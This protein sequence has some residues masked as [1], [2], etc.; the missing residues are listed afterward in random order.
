VAG[1]FDVLLG[2]PITPR[3]HDSAHDIG[4]FLRHP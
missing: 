2:H 1:K 3:V 4:V